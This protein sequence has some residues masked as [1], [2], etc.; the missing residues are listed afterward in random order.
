MPSHR[1]G[2]DRFVSYVTV[3]GR[4]IPSNTIF[5]TGG[6]LGSGLRKRKIASQNVTVSIVTDFFVQIVTFPLC[7]VGNN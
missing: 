2:R 4:S 3:N 1:A 5:D 6:I 7:G